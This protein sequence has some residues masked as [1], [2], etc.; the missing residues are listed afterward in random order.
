MA[1]PKAIAKADEIRN[2]V[3]AELAYDPRIDPTG[4]TVKNMGGDVALNGTVP[5]YPQYLRAAEAARRVQ[6]VTRVHNHLMVMLPL[7]SYRDDVQ[8][9]TAANNALAQN[10]TLPK[11][12]EASAS[13][14]DVW[15]TGWVSH[16]TQRSDAEMTIAP[17]VGVRGISNDITVMH[18]TASTGD[19]TERVNE[20]LQRYAWF[21]DD[22]TIKVESQDGTITLSGQVTTWTEHDAAIQAAWMG[23]GVKE[24]R[25]QVLVTGGGYW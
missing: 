12:L 16:G 8:L 20:A 24:V 19:T 3:K 15:L 10:V 18:D 9:T 4:I 2:S 5:S 7:D 13:D 21:D 1:K 6:G 11:T 23:Q 22:S 17:L 14:G 25:D